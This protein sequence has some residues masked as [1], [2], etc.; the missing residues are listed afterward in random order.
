MKTIVLLSIL[1]SAGILLSASTASAQETV[2]VEENIVV[3]ENVVDCKTHY[4]SSWRDNWF[5][6]AGGG[7][8]VPFVENWLSNG[9]DDHRHATAVYN[10]GVGH[11][12]S[13]YL[14]LRFSGYYGKIHFNCAEMSS[15]QMANLNFDIM[16]D[17]TSSICGVNPERVFS[18]IPFLGVGG[19]YTWDFKGYPPTILTDNG[20]HLKTRE[21]TLPV[22]AGFQLRFRLCRYVDFFAEARASFYGDN[23]N[24]VVQN[25]PIECNLTAIGGF[26]VTIG[27]RKFN[28][29]NPCD[30]LGYVKQLNGQINDLRAE[31][32]ATTAALAAQVV[33]PEPAES[34]TP[35][36][37]AV[38]LLSTVRFKINSAKISD[39]EAVN[40]YNIAQWMKANPKAKVVV[41]GYADRDTGSSEYNMELSNR[42]AQAVIDA[43]TGDYGISADRLAKRA[44]GS[45][46]QP[47]P[48]NDWNRIVIF[49][50]P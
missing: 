5:I 45:D 21:W 10:L 13:P 38:P 26:S 1:G 28:A 16:W 36:S 19:T 47:Y 37:P 27:G 42:R 7:V 49:S 33:Q 50:Q 8:S 15:A 24:N 29:Y 9:E 44:S 4:S 17:M 3:T 40:V 39:E 25:D 18:F 20:R 12:F 11:W 48:E 34:P 35:V 46:V 41:D 43:L 30:Y 22:S 31:L 32:A 2:V 6:Q 23:F 14:A